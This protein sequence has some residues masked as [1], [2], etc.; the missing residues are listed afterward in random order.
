MHWLLTS[1]T[2]GTWLPGDNRGSVTSVRDYRATDRTTKVRVEH[3]QPGEPWE[4]A[5][6]GLQRSATALIAQSPV[7][8]TA[9]Q[10]QIV[11][12]QFVE[13]AK[14]REWRLLAAAVMAN[15]FHMVV[16]ADARIDSTKVLGDFKAWESRALT[17]YSG[18]RAAGRWFTT[19]GSR[20]PLKD[21]RAVEAAV[22]YV[23]RRQQ[24]VLAL[25]D[26]A[27]VRRGNSGKRQLPE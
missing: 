6:K 1:T 3:D 16:S 13:T 9:E 12:D 19:G 22:N 14:V 26:G 17:Q 18:N 8:L 10:S 2:Y 4:P 24:G 23:L 11:C 25:Y 7:L 27:Q 15:H 21:D 5:I 20:R